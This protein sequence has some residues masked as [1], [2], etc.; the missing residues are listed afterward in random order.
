MSSELKFKSRRS[1]V[2]GTRGMVATSQPLDVAD[3]LQIMAEGGK[4]VD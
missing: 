3:G 1:P 4:A 2:L